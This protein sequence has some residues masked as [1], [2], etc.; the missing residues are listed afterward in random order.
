MKKVKSASIV[1]VRGARRPIRPALISGFCSMKRL[2]IFLLPLDGILVQCRLPLS[3]LSG[4][5]QAICWF[6][7]IHLGGE[8]QLGN[9]GLLLATSTCKQSGKVSRRVV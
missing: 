7:F 5:P 6:P 9:K 8:V 2:G 1:I 3:I 4:C